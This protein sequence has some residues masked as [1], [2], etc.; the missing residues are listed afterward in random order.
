MNTASFDPLEQFITEHKA[1]FESQLSELV[2]IPTVSA[3]PAHAADIAR[4]AEY[5]AALLEEA[6]LRARIVP[7]GGY[8]VIYGETNGDPTWPAVTLYNHIDVQPAAREEWQSDP[9]K[10]KIHDDRYFGRGATDDKGPALTALAAI[11]HAHTQGL[12]LNFKVI[13][14][15]EEEIGSPHFEEFLQKEGG[16]LATDS[17]VISDT[18]WI[19]NDTPAIPYGLRGLITFEITLATGEQDVHSGLAGGVARNPIGELARLLGQCYDAATG[20]V[21]IPGF[22]DAVMPLS[23]AELANFAASGFE[24]SAFK[25]A[26][27]L[28][29]I[30]SDENTDVMRRIWAQPAFEVHGIVGGHA[31][32]GVKTIVPQRATAKLSA[33]L[34]PNQDPHKVFKTIEAFVTEKCPDASITLEAALEPYLG[35]HEGPYATAAKQAYVAAFNKEPAFIREG[36]S[37]GAALSMKRHLKVPLIF[38]GLSLPEH[39]YHA[40]NEH[41]DWRQVSGGIRL[42]SQYFYALSRLKDKR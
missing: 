18:I 40:P 38:L 6:G 28:H 13:W 42:F 29:S 11:K 12:P 22:Y 8:P 19:K 23:D 39:G 32:P 10:L 5:A 34:V 7:T 31:G 33:R 4:G 41:F 2:S 35:E 1:R 26:H 3:D 37:I 30:R 21:H 27:K 36:G 9:F 15:L 16:Q 20:Q 25:R 24:A 14:E 17:V